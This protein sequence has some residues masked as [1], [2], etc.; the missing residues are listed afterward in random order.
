[1]TMQDD[2]RRD[3]EAFLRTLRRAEE[4]ERRGKLKIFFGMC[5]GV[6]K[7]YEMLQAAHEARKKGHNVAIGVVETHGRRET[8][9]LVSD[10]PLIPRK[11]VDYR[12]ALL[13]EMD[14]DAILALKPDLVL[15]D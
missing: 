8:E 14:I 4:R 6:G 7:T 11:R 2:T 10:L 1:M 3:P 9:A 5:A 12:G 13:E 15:V